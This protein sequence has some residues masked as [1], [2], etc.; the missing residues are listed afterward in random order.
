M[1]GSVTTTPNVTGLAGDGLITEGI[2]VPERLEVWGLLASESETVNV[3]VRVPVA[4]GPK[5]TKIWQLALLAS[6]VAHE[7]VLLK[8]P[9]FT[10][11]NEIATPV[12]VT[13]VLFVSVKATGLS[14]LL[15]P[16]PV[17]AKA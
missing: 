1:E 5:V 3:A 7:V 14:P 8:S 10:P 6:V 13:P 2:P 12:T 11:L 15:L 4:V 16:M 9:A 17:G